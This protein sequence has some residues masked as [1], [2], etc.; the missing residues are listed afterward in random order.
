MHGC[1]EIRIV[2]ATLVEYACFILVF[3]SFLV[4]GTVLNNIS[5][6][7]LFLES[8][9]YWVMRL[10]FQITNRSDDART[11][12]DRPSSTRWPVTTEQRLFV[13][14]LTRAEALGIG[15]VEE[16]WRQPNAS[17]QFI[18]CHFSHDGNSPLNGLSAF[19]TCL[20]PLHGQAFV[21]K[22]TFLQTDPQ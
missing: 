22:I 15:D 1:S 19:T 4:T 8:T 7:K 18:L 21:T 9:M 6:S 2:P 10:T 3:S 20:S 16:I 14:F 5:R 11:N 17:S 13:R 12:A